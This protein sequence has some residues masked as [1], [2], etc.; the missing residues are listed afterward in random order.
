MHKMGPSFTTMLAFPWAPYPQL[1]VVT[2]GMSHGNVMASGKSPT[3]IGSC[4][5]SLGTHIDLEG[6]LP[7]TTLLVFWT[8]ITRDVC[9]HQEAIDPDHLSTVNGQKECP[10]GSESGKVTRGFCQTGTTFLASLPLSTAF[11]CG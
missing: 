2:M 8:D 1:R 7:N 11:G 5:T 3:G 10:G 6:I 9:V 4:G